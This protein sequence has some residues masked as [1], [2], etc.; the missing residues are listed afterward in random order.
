MV[1]HPFYRLLNL[2]CWCCRG[3]QNHA[4]LKITAGERTKLS[5]Y[6]FYSEHLCKEEI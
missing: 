5:F 1:Y 4:W 6:S 2:A 3:E